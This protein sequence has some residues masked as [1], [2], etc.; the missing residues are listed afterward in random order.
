MKVETSTD[1]LRQKLIAS[2]GIGNYSIHLTHFQLI[3][4]LDESSSLLSFLKVGYQ[5]T[6]NMC[7][8]M[9]NL[10][11]SCFLAAT[12][13]ALLHIPVVFNYLQ[14]RYVVEHTL[15][16][17]DFWCILCPMVATLNGTLSCFPKKYTRE[18]E[19]TL[20]SSIGPYLMFD[21]LKT[22][23]RTM[24]QGAQEDAHELFM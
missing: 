20:M 7:G 4:N 10:G 18:N 12:I 1:V 14:S 22:I 11:N 23:C 15:K 2:L 19:P 9:Y 21:R 13:Q 6:R 24:N 3:P 16:C 17:K 5:N 8:G